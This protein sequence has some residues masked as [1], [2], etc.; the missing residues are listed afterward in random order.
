MFK[1]LAGLQQAKLFDLAHRT[2]R[3][4]LGKSFKLK[5]RNNRPHAHQSNPER[6][7]YVL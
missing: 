4:V 1:S 3:Q 2:L 6:S 5:P 7:Q